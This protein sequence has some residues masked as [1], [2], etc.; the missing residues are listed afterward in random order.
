VSRPYNILEHSNTF[1][2]L[3]TEG[4]NYICRFSDVTNHYAPILGAYDI[5]LV[6][7]DFYPERDAKS[8]DAATGHTICKL[9]KS[10]FKDNKHILTYV[11]DENDGRQ[12]LRQ[13]KFQKWCE[14]YL[15]DFGLQPINIILETEEGLHYRYAGILTHPDFPYAEEIEHYLIN[16]VKGIVEEKSRM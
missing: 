5:R 16:R 6:D 9:I 1:S 4:V 3:N 8:A 14:R 7:F 12:K 2:F 15:P 11:C 10:Q 13:F